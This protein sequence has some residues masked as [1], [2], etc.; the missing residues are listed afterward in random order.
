MRAH[1]NEGRLGRRFAIVIGLAALGV[2]A[3]GAQTTAAAPD[4]VKYDTKVTIDRESHPEDGVLWHGG[5]KSK[6]RKCVEGRRVVLLRQRPGPDRRLGSSDA[7]A[8]GFGW[9]W[10]VM[11]PTNGR[12][13]AKAKETPVCRADRSEIIENGDLCPDDP[14]QIACPRPDRSP[15]IKRSSHPRSLGAQTAA[16]PNVVKYRTEVTIAAGRAGLY[17]GE[18]RS[19]VRKCMEGRRVILF[20]VRPGPDRKLDTARRTQLE[21]GAYGTPRA[22]WGVVVGFPTEGQHG[23]VYAKVQREVGDGFVCRRDRS[24]T[25]TRPGGFS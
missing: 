25:L 13:Y 24:D 14:E 9:A 7:M 8:G 1:G 5:L 20:K 4:V 21:G 17:H 2:M 11:A 19:R 23:D 18:V 6:A 10:E 16:A 12:V 3:L 22:P 15:T